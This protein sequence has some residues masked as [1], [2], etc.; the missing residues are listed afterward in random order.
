MRNSFGISQVW[1]SVFD[2]PY[3]SENAIPQVTQKV[4]SGPC[5]AR[6]WK[7]RAESVELQRNEGR[8]RQ[9]VL[10]RAELLKESFGKIDRDGDGQLSYN[11]FNHGL[12]TLG[13][14]LPKH[15]IE[16][17][18]QQQ[19]QE[20]NANALEQPRV[21]LQNN[22]NR[23]AKLGVN[24]K[25]T[26][27][28]C[29]SLIPYPETEVEQ[30]SETGSGKFTSIEEKQKLKLRRNLR[31]QLSLRANDIKSKFLAAGCSETDQIAFADFKS[32]LWEAGIMLSEEDFYHAWDSVWD[33]APQN[34]SWTPRHG[35][36]I[37]LQQLAHFLDS[38][39]RVRTKADE[40][41]IHDYEKAVKHARSASLIHHKLARQLS[42]RAPQLARAL[43]VADERAAGALPAREFGECLRAAGILL[44]SDDCAALLD[45]MP[46]PPHDPALV[47]YPAFLQQ[48]QAVD[49]PAPPHPP[50]AHHPAAHRPRDPSPQPSDAAAC[51]GPARL[52]LAQA[53]LERRLRESEREVRAGL[54]PGV[55]HSPSD[56]RT[57][58]AGLG[59]QLSDSDAA[60]LYRKAAGH[61]GAL[62]CDRLLG[63]GRG[64]SD[65]GSP[66]DPRGGGAVF[67]ARAGSGAGGGGAAW[68]TEGVV[69]RVARS[70]AANRHR[71]LALL[72]RG[73]GAPQ[74]DRVPAEQFALRLVEAVGDMTRG[75]AGRCAAALCDADGLVDCA[76][77]A[78]RVH[79]AAAAAAAGGHGGGYCEP[80]QRVTPM[81][82]RST[83]SGETP[84][85]RQTGAP[86][87]AAAGHAPPRLAF[88]RAVA[89][90]GAGEGR[91]GWIEG[92]VRNSMRDLNRFEA[93]RRQALARP[94]DPGRA[95]ILHLAEAPPTA[96]ASGS[97]SRCRWGGCGVC[98]DAGSECRGSF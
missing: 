27:A 94:A 15:E 60:H 22:T 89:E 18:W 3:N 10:D 12:H 84:R 40:P 42:D 97:S 64:A 87:A 16:L 79:A 1:E 96:P 81:G 54:P 29:L 8:F 55:A 28:D 65:P 90:A 33:S 32:N 63:A 56:F 95:R 71:L 72:R 45:A 76:A 52:T 26:I 14:K 36:R 31:S 30:S 23:N 82:S 19:Q 47:D 51:G 62:S 48:M 58:L 91:A 80:D 35:D 21:T 88:G 38:E 24:K 86:P 39:A 74:A 25:P 57:A 6:P 98:E 93:Q 7:S 68:E 2:G 83:Q 73:G 46:R 41:C 61:G 43:R 78:D 4:N 13:I 37:S 75:E 34:A 11:E 49:G 70:R 20:D 77:F 67:A 44:S 53:K 50:H 85:G 17:I 5:K 9:S 66:L 92:V 59:L 69:A